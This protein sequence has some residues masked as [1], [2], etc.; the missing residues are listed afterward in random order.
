MKETRKYIVEF[1]LGIQRVVRYDDIYADGLNDAQYQ[2]IGRY[3]E[4]TG[5]IEVPADKC[6]ITEFI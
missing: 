3:C 4:E 2:A 5:D 6:I 1:Y